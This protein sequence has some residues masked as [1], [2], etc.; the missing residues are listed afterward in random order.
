MLL[1]SLITRDFWEELCEIDA[2]P[3]ERGC[4]YNEERYAREC[5][6]SRVLWDS[7]PNILIN[8]EE[9]DCIYVG[10]NEV[11]YVDESESD[12]VRECCADVSGGDVCVREECVEVPRECEE[13]KVNEGEEVRLRDKRKECSCK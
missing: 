5:G 10:K 12:G 6:H 3:R 7:V 11:A 8:E 1:L 4:D 2:P 9:D 13:E